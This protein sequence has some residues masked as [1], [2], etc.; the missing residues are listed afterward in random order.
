MDPNIKLFARMEQMIHN[1]FC[2]Y[3]ELYEE[4]KKQTIQTKP[5]VFMKRA[6]PTT[7]SA[8]AEDTTSDRRLTAKHQWSICFAF[9]YFSSV[10]VV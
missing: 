1:T 3:C 8:A 6:T 5:T 10:F 9:Y 4:E 2:P 7:R